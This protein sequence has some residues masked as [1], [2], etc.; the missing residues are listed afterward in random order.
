MFKSYV[1]I[2]V[3]TKFFISHKKATNKQV[4]NCQPADMSG[5]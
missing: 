4:K 5:G 3:N 1:A 2:A